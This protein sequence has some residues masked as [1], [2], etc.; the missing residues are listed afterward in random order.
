MH[1]MLLANVEGFLI[2]M[3]RLDLI[4]KWN[5]MKNIMFLCKLWL[6]E[7]VFL[8]LEYVHRFA[9]LGVGLA[10]LVF[11]F[12]V[13]EILTVLFMHVLME[14]GG[15]VVSLVPC[16]RSVAGSNPTLATM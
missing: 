11:S 12:I 10:R 3:Y 7:I 16:V 9:A 8:F 4:F 13:Y 1:Y 15:S 5:Y 14:H 6:C 2:K